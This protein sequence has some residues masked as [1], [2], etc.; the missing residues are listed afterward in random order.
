MFVIRRM[1]ARKLEYQDTDIRADRLAR[2]EECSAEQIRVQEVLI[3][4]STPYAKTIK[5][6]ELPHRDF[7]CHLEA[8]LEIRRNV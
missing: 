1:K 2:L 6:G 7:I 4:L 5:I 3:R 8:E